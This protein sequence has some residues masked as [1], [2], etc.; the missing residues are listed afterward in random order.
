ME[1]KALIRELQKLINESGLAADVREI[2]VKLA[3]SMVVF[4]ILLLALGYSLNRIK[5]G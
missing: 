5:R 3:I 4:W 1:L 2:M